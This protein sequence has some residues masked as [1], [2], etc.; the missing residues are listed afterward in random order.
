MT[1]DRGISNRRNPKPSR[2]SSNR[3]PE[4]QPIKTVKE[5]PHGEGKLDRM[6]IVDR[7]HRL[8]K[9]LLNDW[10]A[11][12]ALGFVVTGGTTALSLAFLFKLPAVPNCP[13]I[14]W[15]LASA[16]LRLHCAEIAANKRTTKDLLEAI[17]LVKSLPPDHP[18]YNEAKRFIELWAQ[19]ILN[20][21][22]E[23]FQAG[24]LD[25]AIST[26][27][28][29]PRIGSAYQQVE[30]KITR[31][32]Q[33]WTSAETLYRKAEDALRKQRVQIA[34]TEAGRLL[35]IDNI[36]WQTTKYQELSNKITAT[37]EDITKIGKAKNLVESGGV[38]NFLEA[39]KLLT[40][41]GN[42]SYVYQVAQEVIGETSQKMLDFAEAALDRKD[43]TTALDVIRQ[44]PTS[45]N[46]QKEVED[47]ETLASAVSRIW[48]GA[49]EDYDAAIAQA[50]KVGSDRP[51]FSRAQ[52]LIARWQAEKVDI[53]QLNRARQLAQ[54][55]RPED[56]QAAIATASQIPSS[57]PK[58]KE[59]RQLI[60]QITTEFQS[61]EDRPLI[62]Q[63]EQIANRGDASSLQQAIDLLSRISSR[64]ALGQEAA[65]KRQQYARQLQSIRDQERA[66]T[67]PDPLVQDRIEGN[68][69]AE[70]TLQE[71][72]T[73]ANGGTVDAIADAIRKADSVALSSPMREEARSL[74]DQ[75][76]QQL[77]QTAM[78][79]ASAD[80]AGAIAIAQ[81][82]PL[83]T[84]AHEQAQSLIPLWQ[85]NLR[86]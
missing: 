37:R 50:Q 40:S 86:R 38:K 31:W 61:S 29:V 33:I 16:S 53:A 15:P 22:E 42:Q 63:A 35:S 8:K 20:L 18:L 70:Q 68:A 19:E 58:A 84:S 57:N 72:R 83:G 60:D 21:G 52:R 3:T 65:T 56:L 51:L 73:I 62:D 24:R 34:L 80:P 1:R 48:N 79:Q 81:K 78:S 6:A 17:E 54:S 64:R 23:A 49:P 47:F 28:K 4:K 69:L 45:A 46:L 14:F 36:F 71:A 55:T 39:I 9:W 43:L 82:I 2:R 75:W 44:I 5:P 74:I 32:E 25:E 76:S 67:Q 13:S 41:I 30:D 77:L 59:A 7:F 10:R 11:M 12:I 66:A 26:A 85:Q 27:R